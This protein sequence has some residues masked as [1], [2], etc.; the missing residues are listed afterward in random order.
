MNNDKSQQIQ[1]ST[2]LTDAET[3]ILITDQQIS[4]PVQARRNNF[5][6]I[7]DH[8]NEDIIIN[9]RYENYESIISDPSNIVDHN[10]NSYENSRKELRYNNFNSFILILKSTVGIC[11]FNYH[12]AIA[13]TGIYLSFF[14]NCIICYITS[15]GIYKITKLADSIESEQ[16]DEDQDDDSKIIKIYHD[17]PDYIKT[18]TAYLL[19]AVILII[20][21]LVTSSSTIANMSV[22]SNI[23]ATDFGL[24]IF[25]SKALISLLFCI[26]MLVIVIPEKIKYILYFITLVMFTIVIMVI[27]D[28]LNIFANEYDSSPKDYTYCNWQNSGI[29]LGVSSYAY[30]SVGSIFNVRR[31][32]KKR[33]DMPK[34]QIGVFI[35][36]SLSY[37]ITGL[38]V[39]LAYGNFEIKES[40]FSYYQSSRPLMYSLGLVFSVTG[41][42]NISYNVIVV[43]ENLEALPSTRKIMLDESGRL[44][45]KKIAICRIVAVLQS[46]C[47]TLISDD[48]TRILNLSGGVLSPIIGYIIPIVLFWQYCGVNGKKIGIVSRAHDSFIILFG[49]VIGVLSLYSS[50]Y[51]F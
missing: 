10:R 8:H 39:Y 22:M 12:F 3:L 43:V 4:S 1:S 34:L 41:I 29:F 38:C 18:K 42:F 30:E 5:A 26:L 47:V 32:M 2:P 7:D 51:Q 49:I 15:Y 25:V 9:N 20:C 14:L 17:I 6:N 50:Y 45:G 48:F 19:K 36:V 37:Y 23:L 24:N 11:Y 21:L 31:T 46:M 13:K 40:V 28:S 44:S 33:S 27:V 16:N 35:F